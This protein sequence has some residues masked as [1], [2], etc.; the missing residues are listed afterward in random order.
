MRR[1]WLDGDAA[2]RS[3]GLGHVALLYLS[4]WGTC[5]VVADGI[6]DDLARSGLEARGWGDTE[7]S[8]AQRLLNVRPPIGRH[9]VCSRDGSWWAPRHKLPEGH[10][11]KTHA[12]LRAYPITRGSRGARCG[13]DD[14]HIGANILDH[15]N[16]ALD[17]L[18]VNGGT[19]T[20]AVNDQG[21]IC[22]AEDPA[23]HEHVNLT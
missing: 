22:H 18:H 19:P 11:L 20:L 12:S 13:H 2:Q 1:G 5:A 23:P 8:H 7:A 16:E 6:E 15:A 14:P 3:D 21:G 4:R 9:P 17:R 10:H